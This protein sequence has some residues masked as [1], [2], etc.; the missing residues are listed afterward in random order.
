MI[1]SYSENVFYLKKKQI[2]CK[3]NEYEQNNQDNGL[4]QLYLW[5]K[6][7][8]A[9]KKTSIAK[10]NGRLYNNAQKLNNV[11]AMMALS[12]ESHSSIQHGSAQKSH[13]VILF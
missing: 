2:P 13:F 12:L 9:L 5:V 1:I 11:E 7:K 4:A 10:K 8:L 6:A 3:Y